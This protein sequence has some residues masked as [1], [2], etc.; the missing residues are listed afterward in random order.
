MACNALEISMDLS[1]QSC[2]T[3]GNVHTALNSLSDVLT[4]L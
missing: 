1:F 4:G 3:S 2:D